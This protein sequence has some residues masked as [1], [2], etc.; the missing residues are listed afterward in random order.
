MVTPFQVH[1]HLRRHLMKELP[2]T[3]DAVAQWCRDQF[4]VKVSFTFSSCSS[5]MALQL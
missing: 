3:D 5:Y 2:E 4:V 1:V